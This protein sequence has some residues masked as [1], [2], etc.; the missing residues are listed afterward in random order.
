M[1]V[2]KAKMHANNTEIHLAKK[3]KG[4]IKYEV[5][6]NLTIEDYKNC[7][8]NNTTKYSNMNTNRSEKHEIYSI[9]QNKVVLSADDDKYYILP[10]DNY[11]LFWVYY[12][13]SY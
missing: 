10:N 11:I 7:E 6:T 13:I 4:V 8:F 1:H 5:A 2:L 9:T 3:A 12:S